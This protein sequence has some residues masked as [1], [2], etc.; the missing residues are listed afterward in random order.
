[1]W[2]QQPCAVDEKILGSDFVE[3]N[4]V[5]LEAKDTQKLCS[6]NPEANE[7]KKAL[8]PL[9]SLPQLLIELK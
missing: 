8:Q 3:Y 5:I 6:G 4:H 7:Q 1:M 2:S 9:I